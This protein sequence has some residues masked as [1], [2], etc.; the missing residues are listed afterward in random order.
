M[1]S[2]LWQEGLGIKIYLKTDDCWD[3]NFL[4]GTDNA[5]KLNPSKNRYT[6]DLNLEKYTGSNFQ[7]PPFYFLADTSSV[8]FVYKTLFCRNRFSIQEVMI[9]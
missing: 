3:L 8:K 2:S 4:P 1:T 7:N 6:V 9:F 5:L